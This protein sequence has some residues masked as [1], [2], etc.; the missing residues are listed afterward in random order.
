[1]AKYLIFL[2]F[3]DACLLLQVVFSH[4]DQAVSKARKEIIGNNL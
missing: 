4:I 1:M 2:Q 3:S